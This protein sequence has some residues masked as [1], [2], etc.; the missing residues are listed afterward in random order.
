MFTNIYQNRQNTQNNKISITNNNN[1][2]FFSLM[3]N[4]VLQPKEMNNV[5]QRNIQR[6]IIPEKPSKKM[7]WG[8]PTWFLF[9]TLAEK[10]KEEDFPLIRVELLNIIY[11]I[12]CI[13]P[14]PLCSSHAKTHLNGSNFNNIR[15]KQ[16]LKDFL[17][18]FHNTVNQK[19]NYL[20]FEYDNLNEK[21]SKAITNMIIQN[22]ILRFK[23]K[24][25]NN[26]MIAD[27]FH[28]KRTLKEFELWLNN[29][30]DKFNR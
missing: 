20:L 19:K 16:Q 2:H 21:Y 4:R 22:F 1:H 3:N 27:D 23:S 25:N 18:L 10:V 7:E 9:H 12:C 15:T 30:I 11:S 17:F 26:L 28:R 5:E 24:N 13:L 29:N 14:C 6:E 8:E